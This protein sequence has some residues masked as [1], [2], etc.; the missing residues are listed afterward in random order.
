MNLPAHTLSRCLCS[1]LLL[2][3]LA[4]LHAG[5]DLPE[6]PISGKLHIGFFQSLEN[7][8]AMTSNDWN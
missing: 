5:R 8:G 6:V 3:P 4:A 2:T 1:A 7:R